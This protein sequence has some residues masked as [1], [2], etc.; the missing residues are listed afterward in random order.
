MISEYNKKWNEDRRLIGRQF[1]KLIRSQIPTCWICGKEFSK[2]KEPLFHHIE[3]KQKK[4]SVNHLAQHCYNTKT[5]QNEMLKTTA[6]CHMCH[7]HMHKIYIDRPR[8][9]VIEIKNLLFYEAFVEWSKLIPSFD[10]VKPIVL[11]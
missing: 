1:V 7:S 9:D 11:F 5:I 6:I 3:P 2:V 4:E 10:I 8:K